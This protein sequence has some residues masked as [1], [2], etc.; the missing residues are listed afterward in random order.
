M[1]PSKAPARDA[2]VIDPKDNVAVLIRPCQKGELLACALRDGA[3]E[4]VTARE[5]I[6]LFHKIARHDIARGA[7]VLKYGEY[8]GVA[9]CD[10]LCGEHVHVHNCVSTDAL[11]GYETK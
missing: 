7:H 6:P 5:D 8:I 9:S 2:V 3:V 4:T 1:D 11:K 10:I